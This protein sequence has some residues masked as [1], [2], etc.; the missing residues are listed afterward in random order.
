MGRGDEVG[1]DGV[2]RGG[3]C[4]FGGQVEVEQRGITGGRMLGGVEQVDER[5]ME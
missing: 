4:G 1:W 2:S 3:R 5:W